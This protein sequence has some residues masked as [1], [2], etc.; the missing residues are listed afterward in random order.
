MTPAK[1]H[2]LLLRADEREHEKVQMPPSFSPHPAKKSWNGER[3]HVRRR[4]PARNKTV[5]AEGGGRIPAGCDSLVIHHQ[6]ETV[7]QRDRARL[8]LLGCA[9]MALLLT[10]L[11]ASELWQVIIGALVGEGLHLAIE[12]LS[13]RPRG[14]G[15]DRDVDKD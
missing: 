15:E 8:A 12:A 10:Q 14:D 2:L 4:E 11:P 1:I 7:N 13:R 6:G 3:R 5:A 9:A